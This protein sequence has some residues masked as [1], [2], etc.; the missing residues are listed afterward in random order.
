MIDHRDLFETIRE[1]GNTY[2]IDFRGISGQ[3][4]KTQ[5]AVHSFED[6]CKYCG[7][8]LEKGTRTQHEKEYHPHAESS[9]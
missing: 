9:W 2:M 8:A 5:G 3:T 7:V 4:K 6:S 1:H